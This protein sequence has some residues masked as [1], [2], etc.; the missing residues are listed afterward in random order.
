MRCLKVA[1][2]S[3]L[4]MIMVGPALATLLADCPELAR[5][6]LAATD[7][8]CDTTR[9]NEACYGH[10]LLQAQPQPG[11]D[12]F[13]FDRP[14][15]QVDV[16]Q[17]QSLRLSAMQLDSGVWGVA[18]MR[19]Q[20]NIPASQRRDVTLL[21]FGDV[22]IENKVESPTE[23]DVTVSGHNDVSVLQQP[24]MDAEAVGLLAPGQTVTAHERLADNSWLRVELPENG[25]FGWVSAPLVTSADSIE[26]LR[27]ANE[28][29]PFYRP[30]Q[31]FQFS[32]GAG[33]SGC[34]ETPPNGLLIR[35]P[36]GVGEIN[37]LINE[38]NIRL[39]STVFFQ[40]Q[41]G[42]MMTISTLEGHAA[43]EAGGEL[44]V[45]TTGMQVSVPLD[46][47]LAPAGP[48]SG[49]RNS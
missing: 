17:L 21:T 24:R 30:M 20:A 6:A 27:V 44:Q 41:P 28:A 42:S 13:V 18:L 29:T 39:G 9:R 1:A 47:N 2:S 16:A 10:Q 25:E 14:G 8:L 23:L 48:P 46:E 26:A 11:V 5:T 12:S 49:C 43:I 45:A 3:L 33:E 34:S 22:Q 38:V 35:T 19:L 36:E 15:N 40:A 7:Q 4:L 31:A 37:F 32:S